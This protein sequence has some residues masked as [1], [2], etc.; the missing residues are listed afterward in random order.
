MQIPLQQFQD[1]RNQQLPIVTWGD[2]KVTEF[3]IRKVRE[4]GFVVFPHLPRDTWH[5]AI[6]ACSTL[7]EGLKYIKGKLS[8]TPAK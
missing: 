8:G 3:T 4:G 2:V 7:E 5:E 1:Y 6:Y